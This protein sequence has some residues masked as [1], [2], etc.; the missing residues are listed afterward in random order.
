[1][2]KLP[3]PCFIQ[4]LE[5]EWCKAWHYVFVSVG[6]ALGPV[7][8]VTIAEYCAIRPSFILVLCIWLF[9]C[10]THSM[11]TETKNNQMPFFVLISNIGTKSLFLCI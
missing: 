9:L 4:L 3:V 10:F 11:L 5:E 6:G 1:M 8:V 2:V 7:E